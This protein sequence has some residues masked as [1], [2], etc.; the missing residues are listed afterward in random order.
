MNEL[1]QIIIGAILFSILCWI[2][3]SFKYYNYI[4]YG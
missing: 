4:G 3:S 2:T 1:Q